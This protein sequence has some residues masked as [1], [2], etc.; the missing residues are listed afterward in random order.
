MRKRFIDPQICADCWE[1]DCLGCELVRSDEDD[2]T[3]IM[4]EGEV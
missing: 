4:E 1:E 3:D 2:E